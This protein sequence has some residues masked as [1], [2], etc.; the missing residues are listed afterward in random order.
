[1]TTTEEKS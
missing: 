1:M